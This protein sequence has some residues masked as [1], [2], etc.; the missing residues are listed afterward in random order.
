MPIS[1]PVLDENTPST[2]VVFVYADD[3]HAFTFS[4]VAERLGISLATVE[5][6]VARGELREL[7][8]GRAVRI[9]APE[10]RR[11]IAGGAA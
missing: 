2:P 10:L 1:N 3:L 4:Q 11:Y 6:M 8:V 9:S 5:R 7:R